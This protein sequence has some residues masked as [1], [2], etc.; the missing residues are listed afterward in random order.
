MS[1]TNLVVRRARADDWLA[2]KTI[3]LEA[4]RD[5]PEAYGSTIITALTFSEDRWRTMTAQMCYFLVERGGQV[6]GMAAGGLNND[7]AGAHW[8]YGMYV[9]PSARGGA[10]AVM[11]VDVVEEWAR[12]EGATELHLDVT[13]CVARASAFYLK[14][15]FRPTGERHAMFR[16]PTMTLETMRRVIVDA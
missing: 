9:T 5:T 6:V 11:L 10:A 14:L 15:G 4:L 3:R 13:T 1:D 8:L 16:D 2:L 12:G 7:H